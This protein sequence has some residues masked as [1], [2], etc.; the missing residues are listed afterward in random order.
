M[1]KS[2]VALAVLTTI[3]GSALAQS[4]L[5]IFGRLDASVGNE[6][7]NDVSTTQLFSGNLEPSLLGLKGTEDLGGGLKANFA[8]V[9]DLTVDD[10]TAGALRFRRASWV[11]FSGGFG[12]VRAGRMGSPYKDIFD[13]GVSN[14]LYDSAFTPTLIAQ[15]PGV[16]AFTD[17]VSNMIRYDSPNF[18][19]FTGGVAHAFDENVAPSTVNPSITSFNLRYRSGPL[20]VGVGHQAEGNDVAAL[21][22]NFTVLSA[23]YDFKSFRIS[24]QLQLSEEGDLIED[25]DLSLGV[26][27]PLGS[28]FDVSFGFA[29]GKSESNGVTLGEGSALSLGG[30]YKVSKRTKLYA[31]LL[32]GE[33]EDGNGTVVLERR[34]LAAG[35]SHDF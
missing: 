6:S 17:R 28:S 31:G 26:I 2:L 4:S 9:G 8:L 22:R 11:G 32:N 35:V 18:G 19:G 16:G 34:L 20:D 10:G 1:R 27:I 12:E 29:T 3:G 30:T 25:Q 24:G 21:E 13:M 23:A 14:N 15:I 7:I 5:S 33:V